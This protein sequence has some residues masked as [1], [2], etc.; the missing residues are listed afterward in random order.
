M[1]TTTA[2]PTE[3]VDSVSTLIEQVANWYVGNERVLFRGQRQ[4]SWGLVPRLGRMQLRLRHVASLEQAELR[5]LKDFERLSV[6]YIGNRIVQDEWDRMALAQHHGLPTRLLDWTSNPLV[7]LWFAIERPSGA[8]EGAA[9]WAFD[10]DEGDYVDKIDSPLEVPRT[11]VFRPRHHDARIVAQS[12]WFTVHKYSSSSDRFSEFEKLKAQRSSL[13]KFTIPKNFFPAIRD[14][15]A[16]C[17]VSRASLFPD[18][19]GLC[20]AIAWRYEYLADEGEYDA[21]SSL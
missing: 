20:E 4:A 11:M 7:A 13:R 18:L 1:D 21:I 10:A 14:D 19:S 12:G 3:E 2:I 16:R 6:P 17:G 5:M 8:N 9:V 15:L